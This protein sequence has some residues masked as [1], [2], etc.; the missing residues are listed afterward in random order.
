L[1]QYAKGLAINP[2]N[3]N[4]LTDKATIYMTFFEKRNDEEDFNIALGLFNRSYKIDPL[5]QNTLFKISAAYLYKQDC[6]NAWK[7]YNECIKLGGKPITQ[8]YTEALKK[9][10]AN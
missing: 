5:N 9:M 7:F 10:C 1:K 8:E 4:I 2:D 3:S 6:K